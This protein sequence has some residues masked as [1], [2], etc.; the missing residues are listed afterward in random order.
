MQ[1]GRSFGLMAA[2]SL[3]ATRTVVA[4]SR[5]CAGTASRS[6]DG[7]RVGIAL[8]LITS[9]LVETLRNCNV[10]QGCVDAVATNFDAICRLGL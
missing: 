5:T 2:T 8:G 10:H 7:S 1:P 6:C 4:S 9:G 3:W